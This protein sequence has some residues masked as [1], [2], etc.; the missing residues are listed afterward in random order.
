MSYITTTCICSNKFQ[1]RI[2]TASILFVLVYV[3]FPSKLFAQAG[4]APGDFTQSDSLAS[5]FALLTRQPQRPDGIL[6]LAE[7]ERY[8]IWVELNRGRLNLMELQDDGGLLIRKS[9][10]IS[11]GKN[12]YGKEQEGDRLT[13]VG[14]YRLTSF[15]TDNTLDDFYGRGAYPLNYPNTQDLL[16]KRTGHGIWL[17]GLP[18]DT[19]QRP[20]LDSDGCLVVD[21]A[22]LLDLAA[23]IQTGVTNIV[24]SENG[25]EWSTLERLQQRKAALTDVFEEWRK[26][27][28][29]NDNDAYLVHYADHFSDLS[30]DKEEWA[31]DKRRVNN[32]KSYINIATSNTS[33]IADPQNPDIVIV[34]FYLQ[35]S[36]SNYNS[37][38]WKEQL[39]QESEHGWK[40]VYEGN[41]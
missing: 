3:L 6:K 23:Y 26:S 35:Y 18:K 39:W 12:G 19:Q 34:R 14:V 13:P 36:S 30:R 16:K 1:G 15:L 5:F 17:H 27:W 31:R 20:L 11:I 10:P 9:I 28:E 38:G 25:I 32:A 2:S 7:D 24:L 21:N 8:I 33:F 40:I 4:S 22:A 29:A 41:G 37:D